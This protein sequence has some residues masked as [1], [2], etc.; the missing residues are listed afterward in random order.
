VGK[1]AL[2]NRLLGRKVAPSAPRPGVTRHL[3]WLRL[4]GDVDLLD[5]PGTHISFRVFKAWFLVTKL[6]ITRQLRWLRPGGDVDLPDYPRCG[7]SVCFTRLAASNYIANLVLI[8]SNRRRAADGAAKPDGR[9]AA[10]SV[11]RHRRGRVH[12]V[13]GGRRHGRLRAAAAYGRRH[14]MQLHRAVRA[15]HCCQFAVSQVEPCMS[16]AVVSLSTC[17]AQ[18]CLAGQQC[19][20]DPNPHTFPA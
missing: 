5:T 17:R 2:I 8:A 18:G 9:A 1:S 15:R 14:R 12:R 6:G 10:G 19:T 11:Q 13:P 20:A 3:R 16:S 4:G 7:H